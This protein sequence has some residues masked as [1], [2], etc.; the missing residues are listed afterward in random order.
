MSLAFRI[1]N[2]IEASDL[3]LIQEID[4]VSFPSPW[5]RAM[6]E[7]E[8]RHEGTAFIVVLRTDVVAVAGYC[9]YRIVADELQINNV[10]VHPGLR[11]RGFG[12]ALVEAALLHGRSAG[13]RR[14]LLEVRRSNGAAARLY[15]SLGFV[16]VGERSRYYSHPEEDALV[17]ARDIRIPEEDPVA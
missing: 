2:V 5:T 8:L 6:Y 11:G 12:R 14:A 4:R 17:M 10:A 1:E 15:R 16:E 9:A 7:E 13:V 3:D